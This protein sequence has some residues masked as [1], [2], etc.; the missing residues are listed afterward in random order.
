MR[1]NETAKQRDCETTKERC[2]TTKGRCETAKVRNYDTTK[3]RNYE[4]A[5]RKSEILN[6]E[7]AKVR[8]GPIRA[9]YYHA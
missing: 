8:D 7:T 4:M 9:P 1:N 5:M 6:S 2:K 3:V